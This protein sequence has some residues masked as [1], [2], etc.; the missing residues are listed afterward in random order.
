MV[1]ELI[2][3]STG[4]VGISPQVMKALNEPALSHRSPAFKRLY[5]KMTD[6][7]CSAFN[8]RETFVLTGSGTLA[9]EIMLQEIKFICGSGIILSNGEFGCRLTEQA[10]RNNLNFVEYKLEWGTT[11]D[12]KEIEKTL[13]GSSAKWIVFCHCETSTGVINNLEEITALANLYNCMCFVDC[14]SS[15][16]TMPV[17][18]SNITMA[19]ASSGKGLASVPGLA[20]IFSNITPTPDRHTPIYLDLAHYYA[21]SG[22]PFTISSN[23]L[24]ALYVS[25]SQKLTQFQFE[26]LQEYGSHFFEI[27]NE[28]RLVPFSEPNTK[29]F[30]INQTGR[31]N[32]KFIHQINRRSV[33]LSYESPY[34]KKRGWCQIA[35][36][37]YYKKNQLKYVL[38]ALKD[39]LYHTDI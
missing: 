8:V 14:M 38:T 25:I 12:L 9:N 29:V 4:P 23:L 2:N 32:K 33:L 19:S 1:S 34:L 26:L 20:I 27:L 37:G 39:T 11:F 31:K 35:L 6:L 28:H 13:V 5:S 21:S 24:K 16:G 22:I 7:L 15:V 18:L 30:T 36:L 10:R 17:N 3:V